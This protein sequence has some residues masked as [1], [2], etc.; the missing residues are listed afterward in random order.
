VT[1]SKTIHQLVHTLSYGDAISTEVLAL[2]RAF[3]VSGITSEIFAIN[4]HPLLRGKT[5][6]HTELE[7]VTTADLVLHY[8]LGSVLNDL[9]GGWQRGRRTL[10][11]HNITPPKWF[12]GINARVAA[13][14]ERGLA[15]LPKLCRLSDQL[16]ADSRFNAEEMKAMG[17]ASEV[18]DLPVDPGR[19]NTTRNEGIYNLVKGTPGTHVLHVGRL[20]PNK[21]VEDIIKTFYFVRHKIDRQS[22]LWLVG[23]DTDTELYSFSLKRLAAELGLEDSINFVGCLADEEVR[24]LYEACTVYI[25]M[26][27]HEGF[28]LPVVEAMHF[29]CPVVAYAAGAVTDTVGH[30]GILIREKRHAEVAELLFTLG[31]DDALR[32]RLV[33]AGRERVKS[34]SYDRFVERIRELFL[35][36]PATNLQASP[37]AHA[38]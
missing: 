29:G 22:T 16:L 5:R 35:G 26:S 9:Y 25:C 33:N 30:G 13:D 17:F 31:N 15:E 2:Q 14:I 36:N 23:I 11:Y 19:W 10:I 21:C 37:H 27:E 12:R 34:L 6:P 7:R 18:L 8:S 38:V 32:S 3:H 20:A 28:C 24:S 1:T 4:E